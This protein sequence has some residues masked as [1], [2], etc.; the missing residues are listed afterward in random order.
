MTQYI[1]PTIGSS[2]YYNLLPPFD[3]KV[4]S[5]EKYTCKSIR[6]ISDYIANNEDVKQSV[7]LDNGLTDNDYDTAAQSDM[8]VVSLQSGLGHW[9]YVPVNYISTFPITNG[10]PYRSITIACALPALPV[11]RSLTH[12]TTDIQN[13]IKDG[14]GVDTVIKL[15][16]TSRVTLVE[17]TKHDVT[18]ASRA[19]VMNGK[20]TDR[21]RYISTLALLE[22]ANAKIAALEQYIKDNHL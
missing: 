13:V 1:I 3:T 12:I 2:G 6:K 18:E 4:A 8:S 15:V 17:K 14:L 10:V 22:T 21:S 9:V 7:Y 16:E 5:H 19:A 20:V 11:D